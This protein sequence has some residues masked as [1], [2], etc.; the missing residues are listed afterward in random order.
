MP[1]LAAVL[2]DEQAY[3][4]GFAAELDAQELD[5]TQPMAWIEGWLDAQ[6]LAEYGPT[7]FLR[8]DAEV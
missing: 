8:M 2:A 5:V 6:E 4:A 1:N 3:R 7:E